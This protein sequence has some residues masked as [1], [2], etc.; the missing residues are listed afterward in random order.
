MKTYDDIVRKTV[1][2]PDS[3]FR[4]SKDQERQAYEGFRAMDPEEQ[5]LQGRVTQ[6]LAAS[7][8][9]LSQVMVEVEG[10]DVILRGKVSDPQMLDRIPMIVH[11]VEGVKDVV[12]WLVVAR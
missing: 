10:D 1:P 5:V 9:D 11:G 2:N 7:G 12:D 8:I 6:A 3:S 4:P